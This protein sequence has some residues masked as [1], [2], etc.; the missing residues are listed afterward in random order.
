MYVVHYVYAH[1][2]VLCYKNCV[3]NSVLLAVK[4]TRHV[5]DRLEQKN[6]LQLFIIVQVA[7]LLSNI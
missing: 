7:P 6:Y 1:I 2:L 3:S 5:K 4:L